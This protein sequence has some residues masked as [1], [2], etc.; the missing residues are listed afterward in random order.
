VRNVVRR[1]HGVAERKLYYFHSGHLVP[2]AQLVH[3][4]IDVSKVFGN[5]GQFGKHL[6]Q[7]VEQ[8]FAW[9]LFPFAPYGG[10]LI[11]RHF[12]KI[13]ESSEMI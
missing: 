12:P 2:V 8:V 9:S 5:K 6:P 7:Q 4:I 10:C 3:R 13:G 1:W 11:R